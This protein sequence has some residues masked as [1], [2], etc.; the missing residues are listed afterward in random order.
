VKEETGRRFL[1]VNADDFGLTNGV[2]RGIIEAHERGIVTSASLMVRYPA[3]EKAAE[4]A[5]THPELSVGLHFDVQELRYRDRKWE[6]AYRL[7]DT[8]DAEAVGQ[9]FERQLAA[10]QRLLGSA[11]THLDSHQHI[12]LAEPAR[13][14]LLEYVKQLGVPLRSCTPA[15]SYRGSFYGQTDEGDSFPAGISAEALIGAFEKLPPGWTEIGCHPGYTDGLDSVY[16][17]EREEETRVLSS[18]AVRSALN[19]GDVQLRSFHDFGS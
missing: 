18:V 16:S 3:A 7:I 1:I 9:E 6:L 4:Y 13:S 19:R 17:I 2:N 15:I 12:H 11:P 10:F 8:T 5:R 14:V